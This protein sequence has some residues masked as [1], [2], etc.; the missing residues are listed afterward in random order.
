MDLQVDPGRTL[1]IHVI[2]P[3]GQPVGGTKVSGLTDLFS[4]AE[5]EQDAPTFEVH[6]LDPSKPRRVTITHAGRK[7]VGSVYLK[8]DETGP[9]TVRL[10]PWG[11]VTGRIVDDDGKPR[12]SLRLNSL[13]GIYP[14]PPVD[15]ALLPGSTGATASGAPAT[16]NSASR[17]WSPDSSM[18]RTPGRGPWAV[19]ELFQDVTVAPGEVKDLGDLKVIPPKPN[20]QE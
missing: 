9:L 15:Q 8:G 5:N 16:A 19:V 20:G 11:T 14:Q 18:G 17:A 6:A 2:D 4:N 3:E 7:L 12:G 13:L 10:Q 1:T